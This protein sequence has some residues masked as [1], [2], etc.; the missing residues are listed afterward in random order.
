MTSL[1]K[2]TKIEREKFDGG[3]AEQNK[4]R[5]PR[6]RIKSTKDEVQSGRIGRRDFLA[7]HRNELIARQS[8]AN[9]EFRETVRMT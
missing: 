7:A 3:V 9:S 5:Q 1:R 8:N 6:V 4:K 2:N